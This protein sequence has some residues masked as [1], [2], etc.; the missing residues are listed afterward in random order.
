MAKF[1]FSICL[2]VFSTLGFAQ[3]QTWYLVRHFEKQLASD[4]SLT[5]TGKAR[6]QAL[7]AYFADKPLQQ[8]Y[9]TNYQRTMQTANPVAAQKALPI[10]PYDPNDLAGF[11]KQVADLN[12]VL[13]V[14]H[15]NTTP[16]LLSLMGGDKITMTELDYG[17][18]YILHK[19]DGVYQTQTQFISVP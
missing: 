10:Q 9:S 19:E 5:E 11:A 13:V 18:V 16:E 12:H 4:P 8:I 17:T 7:A 14:G 15:S 6:S 3:Q 1:C 2:L